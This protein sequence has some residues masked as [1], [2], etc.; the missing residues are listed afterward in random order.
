MLATP[1][2]TMQERAL[3]AVAARTLRAA[4]QQPEVAGNP[5]TIHL[6]L[7]RPRRA[8]WMTTWPGLPGFRK[9]MDR[10]GATYEHDLLPGWR[11]LKREIKA[12]M[13]P[14]LERLAERGERPTEATR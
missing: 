4:L 5:T 11:Y 12:E 13:I 8:V 7:A 9:V 3:A 14:D 2:A 1:P 10:D 6:D